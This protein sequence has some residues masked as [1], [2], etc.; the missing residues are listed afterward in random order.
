[1]DQLAAEGYTVMITK[2]GVANA[3]SRKA[4]VKSGFREIGVMRLTRIGPRRRTS[5][6]PAGDGLG[7]DL[8]ERLAGGRALACSRPLA[9][10]PLIGR[11]H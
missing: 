7:A 10:P 4:V 5:M 9:I 2:V 6:E 8:S 11:A 1:M 3:P